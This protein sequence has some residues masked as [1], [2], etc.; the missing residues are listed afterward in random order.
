MS[1]FKFES[2]LFYNLYQNSTLLKFIG[3]DIY[4]HFFDEEKNY[5]D[6]Y[7]RKKESFLAFYEFI[8]SKSLKDYL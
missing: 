3:Y 2:I 8:N 7:E 5:N 4:I 6:N 1:N